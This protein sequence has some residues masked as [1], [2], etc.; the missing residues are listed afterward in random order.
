[1]VRVRLGL[2]FWLGKSHQNV[3]VLTSAGLTVTII[4]DQQPWHRFVLY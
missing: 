2:E 4:R 1:M 3:H